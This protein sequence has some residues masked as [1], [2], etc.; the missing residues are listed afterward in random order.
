MFQRREI[1]KSVKVGTGGRNELDLRH[2]SEL[3]LG[4]TS[5]GSSFAESGSEMRY[6]E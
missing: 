4:M 5:S 2:S 1:L 3:E 6:P